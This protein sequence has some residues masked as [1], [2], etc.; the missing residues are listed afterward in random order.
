MF[1]TIAPLRRVVA[2]ALFAGS[3]GFAATVA[4][5]QP[6]TLN[7]N[8]LTDPEGLGIRPVANCYT[9]AGFRVT[10][11]GV[12]CS[13]ELAFAVGSADSP[14]FFPGSPALF[15]NDPVATIIEFTR[16]GGG[17]FSFT[18][19]GLAPYLGAATTVSI[20]GLRPSAASLFATFMLPAGGP[21]LTSFMLPTTFAGL[22][23]VRLTAMN[24]F[25][26]PLVLIDNVTFNA[27]VIPEPAT[28]GLFAIG[29][30]GVGAFA[31]R[32]RA[33]S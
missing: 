33:A 22:S 7:F 4:S 31:R 14:P 23:A 30:L 29:L 16:V 18:S 19:I 2:A 15:L 20:T 32:R 25:D 17:L 28:V 8:S 6:A 26:E 1:R 10:A 9:E 5:A 11:V 27:T 21:V 13:D 12:A 3:M 24:E